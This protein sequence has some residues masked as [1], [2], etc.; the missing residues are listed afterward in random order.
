LIEIWLDLNTRLE[1]CPIRLRTL[2][3]RLP[4]LSVGQAMP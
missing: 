1:A 4:G 2:G 3:V